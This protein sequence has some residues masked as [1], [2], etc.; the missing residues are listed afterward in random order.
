M[1]QYT[2]E[3]KMREFRYRKVNFMFVTDLAA[4]GIDIPYLENVI[5]Y[6]FPTRMKLFIHRAGRTARAGRSGNSYGIVTNEELPYL[7]DLSI[8]TG[9]DRLDVCNDKQLTDPSVIC[10][11]KLPQ[12]LTDE[13]C[14]Y[15]QKV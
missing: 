8:F 6:D 2:R 5:H 11:G 4:R 15:N 7:H 14:F 13:Y 1:D 3:E 10:F 9:K 12:H